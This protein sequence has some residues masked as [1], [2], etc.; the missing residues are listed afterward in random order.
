MR[1]FQRCQR[2][3]YYLYVCRRESTRESLSLAF[4]KAVHSSIENQCISYGEVKDPFERAHLRALMLGYF[5]RWKDDGFDVVAKEI[6]FDC[7]IVNPWTGVECHTELQGIIDGIV[8]NGCGTWIRETK[9]TSEDSSLGSAYWRS[10]DLDSQVSVYYDG[11]RALGHE[12]IGCLYD[13]VHKTSLVPF[14]ATPEDKRKLT[15]AGKPHAGQRLAD[16]TPD[17]YEARVLDSICC[18]PDRYYQRGKVFRLENEEHR[19]KVD[20]WNVVGDIAN[21]LAATKQDA[22]VWTRSPGACRA[23]GRLCDFFEVCTGRVPIQD[24]RFRNKESR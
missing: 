4:G 11:L 22:D 2:L 13:V 6:K 15:R 5:T 23:Y 7:P 9:T 21:N 19:A 17:Q 1:S 24:S 14:K 3:Y 10:L 12:P 8:R 20:L 16:E 18:N